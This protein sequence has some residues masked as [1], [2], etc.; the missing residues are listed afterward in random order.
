MTRPFQ[1]L[2]DR[3]RLSAA[4]RAHIRWFIGNPHVDPPRRSYLAG[5]FQRWLQLFT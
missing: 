4:T 1:T 3:R 5:L 2:R